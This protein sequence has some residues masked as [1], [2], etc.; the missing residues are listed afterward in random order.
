MGSDPNNRFTADH[1]L[2]S[3]RA[4]M[5]SGARC[6]RS[7]CRTISIVDDFYQ[8]LLYQHE[9]KYATTFGISFLCSSPQRLEYSI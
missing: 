6:H 3:D 1:L 5:N 8:C 4:C 7:D 9:C 2:S